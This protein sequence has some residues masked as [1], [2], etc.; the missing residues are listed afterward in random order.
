MT[1]AGVHPHVCNGRLL[2]PYNIQSIFEFKA[3]FPKGM[4]NPRTTKFMNVHAKGKFRGG[5]F[6][7]HRQFLSTAKLSCK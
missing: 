1:F 7:Q 6:L 2:D 3:A 5:D 4:R